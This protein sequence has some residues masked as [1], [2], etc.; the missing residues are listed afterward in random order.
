MDLFKMLIGFLMPLLMSASVPADR[1]C[2]TVSARSHLQGEFHGI[3]F[4]VSNTCDVD[5]RINPR[6][7]PWGSP[8]SVSLGALVRT[9]PAKDLEETGLLFHFSGEDIT[10]AANDSI[11]GDVDLD[12][13]FR[14]F[15]KG[16]CE[17]DVDVRWSYTFPEG[18]GGN[19]NFGTIDFDRMAC[20]EVRPVVED[21]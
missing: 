17:A 7:L 1:V 5:I 15:R 14:G 21:K 18:V 9:H 13:W 16:L 11:V 8:W 19:G 4:T 20:A 12:G 10:I 6:L 3:R 2:L